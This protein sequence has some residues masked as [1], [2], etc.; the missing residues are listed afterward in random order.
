MR[1]SRFVSR[2]SLIWLSDRVAPLVR[3]PQFVGMTRAPSYATARIV[4]VVCGTFC[5]VSPGREILNSVLFL[6]GGH[7][8]QLRRL[9]QIFGLFLFIGLVY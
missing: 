8:R 2:A 9:N 4:K 3:N 6:V 7:E 1:L 5:E